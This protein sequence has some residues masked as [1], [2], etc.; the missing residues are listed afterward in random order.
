ME[1]TNDD[2]WVELNSMFT[3][4][5]KNI[6]INM[7]N[8]SNGQDALHILQITAKSVLG[9]IIL[10]TSGITVDSWIRIL[11]SENNTNR[12]I[13]SCNKIGNNGI[14]TSINKMLIVADDVIGG[15]FAVNFGKFSDGIGSVWY[16]APDTLEW[17]SLDMKYSEFISWVTFGDTDEFYKTLRWSNWEEYVALVNFNEAVL[18]YPFLWIGEMRIEKARKKVVPVEELL[19]INQEYSEKINGFYMQ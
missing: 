10:N 17:E 7:R 14:P 12:G 9:S 4:S 18:I 8:V 1:N 13:L 3:G 2:L 5:S 6:K 15:I 19:N 11:G 16:F